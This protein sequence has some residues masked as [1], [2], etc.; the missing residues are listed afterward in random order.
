MPGDQSAQSNKKSSILSAP[1]FYSRSKSFRSNDSWRNL[2]IAKLNQERCI[3][4]QKIV[5]FLYPT[6][7]HD[8]ASWK[9]KVYRIAQRWAISRTNKLNSKPF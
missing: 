3:I 9:N 5:R 2:G 6:K 8:R 1:E 4:P 7:D